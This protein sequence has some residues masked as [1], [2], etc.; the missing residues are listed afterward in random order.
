MVFIASRLCILLICI[1]FFTVQPTKGSSLR[2]IDLV[3]RWSKEDYG[4]ELKYQQRTLMAAEIQT[5]NTEKKR[6]SVNKT[7]DP[8]K[9][10]KRSIRRGSDPIHNRP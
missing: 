8:N 3:L 2:S 10:S 6:V 4:P 9:S 5:R 7:L 1:G